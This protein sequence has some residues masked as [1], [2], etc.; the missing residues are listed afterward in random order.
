M[1]APRR[2]AWPAIVFFCLT[3]LMTLSA[4]AL[5][6]TSFAQSVEPFS[7]DEKLFAIPLLPFQHPGMLLLGIPFSLT[8]LGFFMAHEM[9]H[10]LACRY[11]GIDCSYPFFLPS[12][13]PFGTFGAV[14]RIRAPITTRRALFDIG[15]AG[16]IMGF[17]VA[18]P[19]TAYGIAAS[20]VIPGVQ[21]DGGLIYGFPG[22]MKIFMV[23]FHPGT[24][25]K[26]LLFH[27]VA[28]AAW[29]GLLATA[30]NLLPVWQ[31]D[32]GHI[33][34]AF[35]GRRHKLL[36]RIFV[37][38][39]IPLGIFYSPSWFVWAALLFFFALRHPVIYDIAKLDRN[40]VALGLVAFAIFVLTFML[41]PLR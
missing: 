36:S 16:P 30:L 24:E 13:F 5:I 8:L 12:P 9:G 26:S 23:M 22:L 6:A 35:I 11:Y 37:L 15:I 27:P 28:L 32:G 38:A 2:P 25:A 19:L 3:L 41:A 17:I 34:Y 14:I 21:D 18:L 7:G 20:K 33:L 1:R 10:Y 40:R 29:I 4:G 31:L 39:L